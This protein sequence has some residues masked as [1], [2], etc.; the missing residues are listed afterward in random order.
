MLPHVVRNLAPAAG[1]F[2]YSNSGYVLLGLVIEAL[3]GTSY[4][5]F[6]Q[7]HVFAPAGMVETGFPVRGETPGL[8]RP[9]EP[10]LDAGAVR[11]GV[12][13]PVALGARG[14]SAGGAVTTVD[15]LLRFADA[16]E[17]GVLLD[18]AHRELLIRGHVPYGAAKDVWYGYGTIIDRSRGVQSWGHGGMAPGT[19]FEFRVYPDRGTTVVV[20][21][22]YNTIAG[23]ELAS[24]LDH[25][26]RNPGP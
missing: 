17:K 26:A 8:A 21:S 25:L 11:R 24:A 2:S 6:V 4:Y 14:S 12:F 20:M 16:L 10:E 7:K 15:D 23:P 18:A 19:Q 1:T 3:A 13:R 5:D 9:Y 22:N